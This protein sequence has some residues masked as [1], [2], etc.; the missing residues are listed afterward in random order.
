MQP[1]LEVYGERPFRFVVDSLKVQQSEG[2]H[3]MATAYLANPGVR[4]LGDLKGKPCTVTWGRKFAA[5]TFY[6]Y[7]DT[8]GEMNGDADIGGLALICLGASS[9]MRSGQPH[10]WRKSTPYRIAS[11][12]TRPYRMSLVVDKQQATIDSFMQTSESDWGA[13]N[14]LAMESGM[15]VI[16]VGTAVRVVDVRRALG[17]SAT[18]A[19]RFLK[20]PESFV[21]LE[22]PSPVGFDTYNF[23]GVDPLGNNFAVRGG[24]ADGIHRHSGEHFES[25]GAARNAE[26]RKVDRQKHLVKA[27]A[28]YSGQLGVRCG[29]LVS[30][31][32]LVWFVSSCDLEMAFGNP[33]SH[34]HL[35]L[36]RSSGVRP[37]SAAV[38]SVPSPVLRGGK[39]VSSK[40]Y[41]VEI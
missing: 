3:D 39:W 32:G 5:Q 16:P 37:V 22:T 8:T 41:E 27:M 15:V 23:T 9:V 10:I 31:E 7:I 40:S 2:M 4:N 35:V 38:D 17:R 30:A 6:G 20:D 25:L 12:L 33:V 19:V 28:T 21:Q 1:L 36:H 18:T 26:A 11:A 24:P 34:T 13:L 29:D 14:L